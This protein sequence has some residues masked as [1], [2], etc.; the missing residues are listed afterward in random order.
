MLM[1]VRRERPD[2]AQQASPAVGHDELATL[3]LLALDGGLA[4]EV[5]VSCSGLAERLDASTQ[6]ASRRLQSLEDAG[7]LERDIVG[8]GQWVAV[9]DDGEHAL[10]REHEDYRRLFEE[11]GQ[12]ELV[13]TV[14]GGMGEGRHYISLPGYMEQFRERLGYEPFAGT[15]NVDLTDESVRRRSALESLDPV[16]IDG[17]QDDE[18]T[19]GPAVCYPTTVETVD[20]DRYEETHVIVPVRTHHDEDQLEVIAPE[21]LRTALDLADDDHLTVHV[22]ED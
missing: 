20:G 22:R 6:T 16:H 17:W 2:M 15:L 21:K 11:P 8:D 5:K 7:L 4:G 1:A 18:R 19:Y 13:G 12:V 14:T 9:T 3:K 10:R